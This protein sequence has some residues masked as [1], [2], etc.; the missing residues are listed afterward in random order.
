MRAGVLIAGSLIWDDNSLR[1]EWR[2]KRLQLDGRQPTPAPIRY[3][4][5]SSSR[6]DTYTMV[7]STS[8]ISEGLATGTGIVVPFKEE[9]QSLP[10]LACE[11]TE[12]WRVERKANSESRRVIS[13]RWGSVGLLINPD[14]NLPEE[15]SDF[16]AEMAINSPHYGR[17]SVAN[18]EAAALDR[19]TGQAGFPWSCLTTKQ[20]PID[21]DVL[22]FTAT[23][24]SLIDGRWPLPDDIAQAWR[25]A[26]LE[27]RYF[28]RNRDWGIT[29]SAD[30]EI[31]ELLDDIINL[32]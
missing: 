11:A 12:L 15:L 26:P 17:L 24:P 21:L 10:D 4:R 16:W 3:G 29:T 25:E 9:L 18:G 1:V 19:D 13:A 31:E 27:A 28:R 30:A 22:L 2:R 20:S 5:R 23:N 32:C 7:F 8:C 14:S 6:S